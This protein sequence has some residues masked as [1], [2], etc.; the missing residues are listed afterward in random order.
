MGGGAVEEGG[1]G[2]GCGEGGW[3][4]EGVRWRRVGVGGEEGGSG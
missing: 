4:W 3:E 1:S 2:R